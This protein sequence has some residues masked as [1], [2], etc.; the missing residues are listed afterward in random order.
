MAQ[1]KVELPRV[2]SDFDFALS[3]FE[4]LQTSPN[5][6][7]PYPPEKFLA[8]LN[9]HMKHEH[10]PELL[11]KAVSLITKPEPEIQD[12]VEKMR[13]LIADEMHGFNEVG[14]LFYGYAAK[15]PDVSLPSNLYGTVTGKT[16]KILNPKGEMY[17]PLTL[18][19]EDIKGFVREF[20]EG[21]NTY[22]RA[23]ELTEDG[24]SCPWYKMVSKKELSVYRALKAAVND[25]AT[26]FPKLMSVIRNNKDVIGIENRIQL[27]NGLSR[28]TT[29][30]LDKVRDHFIIVK[31]AR[32]VQQC[33]HEKAIAREALLNNLFY[34]LLTAH[35]IIQIANAYPEDF[36]EIMNYYRPS[37]LNKI[38]RDEKARLDAE[39]SNVNVE[40]R[41]VAGASS[42]V[43]ANGDTEAVIPEAVSSDNVDAT[44]TPETPNIGSGRNIGAGASDS[45][46]SHIE[47]MKS[48]TELYSDFNPKALDFSVIST[49]EELHA[50]GDNQPAAQ[51]KANSAIDNGA[52]KAQR[53][54]T[55][56]PNSSGKKTV[57]QLLSELNNVNEGQ[58]SKRRRESTRTSTPRPKSTKK[59]QLNDPDLNVGILTVLRKKMIDEIRALAENGEKEELPHLVEGEAG[60]GKEIELS[61]D[62]EKGKGKEVEVDE[63]Y[64]YFT[65]KDKPIPATR[66]VLF[67]VG[68][69]TQGEEVKDNFIDHIGTV[70]KKHQGKLCFGIMNIHALHYVSIFTYQPTEGNMQLIILD[71]APKSKENSNVLDNV[72]ARIRERILL[73]GEEWEIT[74]FEIPQQNDDSGCGPA[75]LNAG[76]DL[77]TEN[78]V[79]IDKDKEK[80]IFHRDKLTLSLENCKGSNREFNRKIGEARAKWEGRLRK[81]T[82]YYIFRNDDIDEYSGK[83]NFDKNVALQEL[84]SEAQELLNIIMYNFF[85][86]KEFAIRDCLR[87]MGGEIPHKDSAIGGLIDRYIEN[88]PDCKRFT[89]LVREIKAIGTTNSEFV[90]IN[91]S[92]IKVALLYNI[93]V[94]DRDERCRLFNFAFINYLK[95][96]VVKGNL[97]VVP[98]ELEVIYNE[99]LLSSNDSNW[100]NFF[101]DT[102]IPKWNHFSGSV[103]KAVEGEVKRNT[104]TK[105]KAPVDLRPLMFLG[106]HYKT[107]SPKPQESSPIVATQKRGSST[108][109]SSSAPPARLRPSSSLPGWCYCY[110]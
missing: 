28:V 100:I 17:E 73:K 104:Q 67:P 52:P 10:F 6:T 86:D 53:E 54:L 26:S 63:E 105:S 7:I 93:Q 58:G 20:R 61:N 47:G 108:L 77:I 84:K 80:M 24:E 107:L 85:H 66:I 106:A 35:Q 42:D 75:C 57:R 14:V 68:L 49:S 13:Q 1:A 3:K 29:E 37:E 101:Q 30:F 78:L 25:E 12:S 23:N 83:Y 16:S 65:D 92:T 99:Y 5:W 110:F 36:F 40:P 98:D 59:Y 72:I 11:A 94:K 109:P 60:K 56:R 95:K 44:N 70:T 39:A 91:A 19:C 79:T 34:N 4:E 82:K 33:Q 15:N 90:V 97:L 88:N 22:H 48:I 38:L 8:I 31:I 27:F 62:S 21:L 102:L 51:E 69:L 81:V 103:V 87:D 64:Y 9:A 18:L 46:D 76:E 2:M 43:A 45:A 50:N 74:K 55:S 71:P 41:V 96:E 89:Q 32:I